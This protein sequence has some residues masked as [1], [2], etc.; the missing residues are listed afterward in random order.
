LIIVTG[1]AGFIGSAFVWKLNNE[2]I[3]DI[4]IVDELGKSAKWKNLSGRKFTDYIQKDDFIIDLKEDKFYDIKAIIHM[5]AC[6]S[7]TETDAEFL[8]K[9]NYAY[10]RD[11]AHWALSKNVRFIYA[12]SAATYGDGSK[13]FS[14]DDQ[15]TANLLPLNIYGY[16]KHLFD[17]WAMRNKVTDKIAGLKFFNV[18]GPNEYHKEGM[19]SVAYTAFHQILEAGKVKLFKS[20][21]D[22]YEHGEQKRDFIYIKDCVEVIWWLMQ[23]EHVNGL[24]NLGTGKARTWNGLVKSIFSAMGINPK[25]DYIDM[26]EKIQDQYQYHTEAEMDKLKK[27]GCPVEFRSLEEAVHDYILG[28]LLKKNLCL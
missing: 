27:T 16:S 21:L 12:S 13:G 8:M 19:V 6:S 24:F 22:E 1:G 15:I 7:T 3:D 25:I 17:L 4:I 26:P 10:T 2:G 18:F 28:Y 5:G 9:N 11:L 20:Y 23:N 14:D